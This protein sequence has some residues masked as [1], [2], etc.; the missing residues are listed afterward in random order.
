[1]QD[2][3]PQTV[4]EQTKMEVEVKKHEYT[5][6][7]VSADFSQ[8]SYNLY[9]RYQIAI[10]KDPPGKLSQHG[11]EGFLCGRNL[12]TEPRSAMYP[13][14]LGNFHQL[15]RIDGELV[16]VGVLDF[17]PSGISAVY[18]FYEPSYGHLSLGVQGALKEIELVRNNLTDQ[19]K[20][21]Y[22]GFYI[23]TCQKMR[24]KGEY[25]PSELLCPRTYV[26]VN[27]EKCLLNKKN[28]GFISLA[29]CSEE[30]INTKDND[31]D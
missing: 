29:E 5:T 31:M 1:M 15:H 28:H 16:A 7:I 21:Y 24:Y 20:Y 14:G 12:I 30:T 13:L 26:W 6:E 19:F 23:D 9:K 4:E 8:E 10:H 2:L 22:M 27:I 11:Y 17:L 3:N 25:L 18:Y